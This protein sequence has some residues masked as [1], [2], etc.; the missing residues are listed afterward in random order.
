MK[1]S[2]AH[3]E[4][5]VN[6]LVVS[7]IA[8]GVIAVVLGGVM[9]W[10]L[11]NY[12]D[13]KNN[14][15]SKVSIAVAEAKAA[16]LSADTAKFLEQ[17]KMPTRQF[18]GPADFGS[19]AFS[20]PKTWSQYVDDNGASGRSYSTYFYPLA[21]PKISD[22]TPYAV[23]VSITSRA[24]DTVL[25]DYKNDV[26]RGNLKTSSVTAAGA[27]G[28][29]LDGTFSKERQGSM[30]IFKVRDKTL[31]IATDSKTFQT[32]FDELIIKSLAFKP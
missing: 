7:N 6:P 28:V 26:D 2:L 14:V 11:I 20:Y 30:V 3:E 25:R 27:Q 31:T 29:R 16:Q 9:T 19:V 4:G 5:S 23:R 22:A 21:V 1:H 24:Y 12:Y 10:A 8:V 18:T 17:E 32:D 13:Q 15:D